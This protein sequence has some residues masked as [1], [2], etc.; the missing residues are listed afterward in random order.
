MPRTTKSSSQ[1]KLNFG[2]DGG[3]SIAKQAER[4]QQR[5]QKRTSPPDDHQNT[6]S[7]ISPKKKLNTGTVTATHNVV[8]PDSLETT[9]KVTLLQTKSGEYIPEY[10]HK[11]VDYVRKGEVLKLSPIQSRVLQWIHDNF[12][13]PND[14]EQN[15]KYGPLSGS[16]YP[17]RVITAYRLGSLE[18]IKRTDD[19]DNDD[20][21]GSK[22]HSVICTVCADLGHIADAC[23]TLL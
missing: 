2:D 22:K 3:N 6:E 5:R 15:R 10:I 23:P 7:Y 16:S 4:V 11:N 13:V 18:R 19:D 9:K 14:F 17:D 8:T 1:R 20:K 12:D 21:I